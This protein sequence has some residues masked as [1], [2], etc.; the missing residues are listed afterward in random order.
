MDS[1]RQ[2]QQQGQQQELLQAAHSQHVVK[3]MANR[4]SSFRQCPHAWLCHVALARCAR[5]YRAE[6]E[7][8]VED[9]ALV[10]PLHAMQRLLHDSMGCN[11]T[12][13]RGS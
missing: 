10:S 9:E 3:L 11:I 5:Q 6:S 1:Q 4:V 12:S 7:C 2:K 8:M 13:A